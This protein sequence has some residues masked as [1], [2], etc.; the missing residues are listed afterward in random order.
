MLQTSA[1]MRRTF[2]YNAVST[3]NK[4]FKIGSFVN[5][6]DENSPELKKSQGVYGQLQEILYT[7]S[8]GEDD[9]RGNH[10][11]NVSPRQ[12]VKPTQQLVTSI[13]H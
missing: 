10:F 12:Y 1:S 2:G 4:L 5:I 6:R 11:C 8:V 3:P 13:R 7:A 9:M